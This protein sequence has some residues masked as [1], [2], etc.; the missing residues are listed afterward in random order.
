MSEN[1]TSDTD[2]E[3]GGETIYI[4]KTQFVRSKSI[5]PSGEMETYQMGEEIEPTEWELEEYLNRGRSH[6]PDVFIKLDADGML[7]DSER[8]DVSRELTPEEELAKQ[9]RTGR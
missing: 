5:S 7:A 4:T 3:S 6:L 8:Y 2:A 9:Y 1:T